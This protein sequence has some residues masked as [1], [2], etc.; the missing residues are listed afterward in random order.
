MRPIGRRAI[1]Y[2]RDLRIHMNLVSRAIP[3]TCMEFPPAKLV[4][5]SFATP[6]ERE[7]CL[8]R[9]HRSLQAGRRSVLRNLQAQ[10]V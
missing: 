8:P 5:H 3:Q 6:R 7:E 1:V 9:A 2:G 10:S 4:L